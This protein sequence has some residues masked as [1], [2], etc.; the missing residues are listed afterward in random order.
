[1]GK[2]GGQARDCD[3]CGKKC[4][5]FL[6][7]IGVICQD[8]QRGRAAAAGR[9]GAVHAPAPEEV[10][11]CLARIGTCIQKVDA[12]QHSM[13]RLRK[14]EFDLLGQLEIIRD[15]VQRLL[16][17]GN[18]TLLKSTFVDCG[19]VA[20][21]SAYLSSIHLSD[22]NARDQRFQNCQAILKSLTELHVKDLGMRTQLNQQ[23]EAAQC[24]RLATRVSFL[25]DDKKVAEVRSAVDRAAIAAP[26]MTTKHTA[27]H[28]GEPT[29]HDVHCGDVEDYSDWD[30]EDNEEMSLYEADTLFKGNARI[31]FDELDKDK[32]GVLS[33][34][35][36]LNGM[37]GLSALLRACRIHKRRHVIKMFKEGVADSNRAFHFDDFT[38]YILD[39]RHKSY[40]AHPKQI[41]DDKVQRVFNIMDKDNDGAITREELEFAYAGV[42]L[43]AGEVV[44][45]KRVSKWV[46]RNFKKYDKD[47][48]A[49]LD[50]NEFKGLLC[51]SG[52]LAPM[53]DFA[54]EVEM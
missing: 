32:D 18:R 27:V 23:V 35:E 24:E 48:S 2:S 17:S 47:E 20:Q 10:D 34:E 36:L 40:V 33:A 44:D 11:A 43:E 9:P 28:S 6:I 22:M 49:T 25:M 12:S 37:T 45:S 29:F 5:N 53:L 21:L 7:G 1:M 51:H 15:L 41:D 39:A 38:N 19:R 4:R 50:L 14:A 42:L 3:L 52:A 16:I 31:L 54:F 30:G 26:P 46:I 8:C 13:V